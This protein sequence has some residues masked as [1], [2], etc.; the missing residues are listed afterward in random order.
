M[1]IVIFLL[2][3][4]AGMIFW[5][6]KFSRASKVINELRKNDQNL[7]G[8]IKGLSFM[9]PSWCIDAI[10]SQGKYTEIKAESLKDELLSINQ[11]K[12]KFILLPMAL[13]VGYILLNL[14]LRAAGA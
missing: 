5:D 13:F 11:K 10:I 2:L 12:Q 3:A 9:P 1:N 8:S 14:L 7:I 4:C 6:Y